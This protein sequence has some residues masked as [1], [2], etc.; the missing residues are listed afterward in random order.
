MIRL[1][2]WFVFSDFLQN[3]NNTIRY[4]KNLIGTPPVY[5]CILA[6]HYGKNNRG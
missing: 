3:I 6:T 4:V 1:S 2:H 5:N